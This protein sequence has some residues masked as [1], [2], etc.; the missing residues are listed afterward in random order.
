[1]RINT[2][3]KPLGKFELVA[4]ALGGMVGGGIF[5]ILGISVEMIGDAT[6]I[7]IFLGGAL[8]YCAAFSYSKLTIYYEDE[9]AT[10]SF[11]K[12]TF[13]SQIYFI[14]LVGWL[15]VFG[16]ISTLALYAYTF[17]SYLSSFLPQY[18]FWQKEIIAFFIIT[19]FATVNIISVNG[20]GKVED[21]LVYTKIV[22]LLVISGL[23]LRNGGHEIHF[24]DVLFKSS[25]TQ[26]I[27][28]SA[29]TFVAFEGFQLTIHAYNE[30]ESPKSNIP[31]AINMA[32]LMATL[33]YVVLA[34]GAITTIP[35]EIIIRDKEF[36]LAAGA[37][38]ILGRIGFI[39]VIT[40]ALFATSS[41]INGTIFGA[42]RLIAVI[43]CDGVFP[44]FL[45]KRRKHIPR[46]AI[47]LMSAL[48]FVF[49]LSGKLQDIVEFGS[50]TFIVVS[51]LMAYSNFHIRTKTRTKGLVA[52]S[53][54][55]F[56]G[57]A[58]IL[59]IYF[60]AVHDITQL[61]RI[62]AVYI[63]LALLAK[64]YSVKMK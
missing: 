19:I 9:G 29:I 1:M 27:T 3:K 30:A 51:F 59:I 64:V 7:A 38:N 31:S 20:M 21:F 25:W 18:F 60:N 13:P 57:L 62:M 55:I 32:I 63:I 46:N 35:H 42:S 15:I 22:L 40:G 36:A 44:R 61:L 6:P 14:S 58:A 24:T 17:S 52:I 34:L 8:A 48:S 56:L 33:V 10:Y 47:I 26:I 11:F 12:K 43:A 23:F 50:I 37:S 5:S 41:A 2:A 39:T 53:A 16:Y 45:E 54:M 4:L 49:I 28:V